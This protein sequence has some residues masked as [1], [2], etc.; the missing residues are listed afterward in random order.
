MQPTRQRGKVEHSKATDETTLE[1]EKVE[2][3]KAAPEAAH[4]TEVKGEKQPVE[5]HGK[6]RPL[7]K[8]DRYDGKGPWESY[9][10]HFEL[11]AGIHCWNDESKCQYL[12]VITGS[13]QQVLEGVQKETRDYKKLGKVRGA[14]HGSG[15]TKPFHLQVAAEQLLRRLRIRESYP[16]NFGSEKATWEA[17]MLQSKEWTRSLRIR[18]AGGELTPECW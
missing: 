12:V 17:F 10:K 1:E 3:L 9:I 13:A 6:Q 5:I 7:I 4:K 16:G 8:P 15:L 18:S 2:N 14:Q 11:C